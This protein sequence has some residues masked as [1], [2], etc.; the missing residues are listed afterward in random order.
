MID[1]IFCWIGNDGRIHKVIGRYKNSMYPGDTITA[2]G[3]VVKKY[4]E[5]GRNLV[6]LDLWAENQEGVT[7]STGKTTVILPS[8]G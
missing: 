1:A 8:R 3:R 2:H 5:G 7:T 6:E 4:T